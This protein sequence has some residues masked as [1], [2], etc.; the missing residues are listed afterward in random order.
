[1]L[2]LFAAFPEV[3]A[4]LQQEIDN[5]VGEG[6]L[7]EAQDAEH[8]PYLNAVIQET[9]RF[10]TVTPLAIPHRA[11]K[12]LHVSMHLAPTKRKKLTMVSQHKGYLIPEGATIFGNL[13]TPFSI[14]RAGE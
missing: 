14:Y 8:L 6:R 4:R 13:R 3:Q 10:H 11:T 9:H 7:P 2:L 5:V 12:D 1:M